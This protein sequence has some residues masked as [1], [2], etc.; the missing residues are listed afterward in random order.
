MATYYHGVYTTEEAT[1]LTVPV[2]SSAAVQTVLG[3]FP[4]NL[5]SDPYHV[6]NVPIEVTR[7]QE[8]ASQVGYSDDFGAYAGCQVLDLSFRVQAVSPVII[9]NVLDPTK[10][11]KTV[12]ETTVAVTAGQGTLKLTGIL[13]DTVTVKD[14]AGTK[15][16]VADAD[17]LLSFD[18]D[19]YLLITMVDDSITE[20][21][22]SGSAI[23]PTMIDEEDIIGGI[24][25]ST[26]KETG[27]EVVRQ[28]YPKLGIYPGT[29]VAPGFS[30]NA[31]VAAALK[32]K[33]ELLGGIFR[34]MAY[35]DIDCSADG[36]TKVS[37]VKT[38]KESQGIVSPHQV[39][40]WPKGKIG[41]KAYYL[42]AMAAAAT[43]AMDAGN[44][45]VPYRSP[46]NISCGATAACLEDGTE[47]LLDQEQGNILNSYGVVTLINLNGM[48][49][50]GN[51]T[52]GYPNTTDPKDRW[53]SSR[54]FFNWTENNFILTYLQ[55][56]DSPLDA[57]LV[58]NICNS[59]NIKGNSYVARGYCSAYAARYDEADNPVTDL[60]NGILRIRMQEAPYPP[61]EKIEAIVSYDTAAL[62]NEMG[63]IEL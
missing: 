51:N 50:W 42:S 37:D 2:T 14:S 29:L 22:V 45:D 20:I 6:T 55:Q 26:G 34:C 30:Q 13:L 38:Q 33:T 41:D 31:N 24:D 21:K 60:L 5:A 1:N 17:Y 47:I 59:E 9:I 54:R 56:V 44:G 28:I 19:G 40:F 35:V 32:A 11:K 58:K 36:A 49:L 10:H 23:D 7:F 3:A 12:A 18:D 48:K 53:I 43:A 61:A 52:A 8:A 25:V 16:Y 39:A 15:S 57:R 46:S 62:A 4:V 27:A 63:G